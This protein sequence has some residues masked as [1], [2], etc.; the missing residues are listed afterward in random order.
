[1]TVSFNIH[2]VVSNLEGFTFVISCLQTDTHL[3]FQKRIR[4]IL[5]ICNVENMRQPINCY[6]PD[7]VAT[8]TALRS[9]W[10][11]MSQ[12]DLLKF[13]G[14]QPVFLRPKMKLKKNDDVWFLKTAVGKN[15]LGTIIVKLLLEETPGINVGDRV[16]TNKSARRLGVTRM[17]ESL[18]PIE[19]SMRM[20]GHRDLMLYLDA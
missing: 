19:K 17:E 10:P 6:C 13:D 20:T 8:Y 9:H 5:S 3:F 18:V 15:T 14:V 11:S 16:F 7:L 12:K 1:M 2:L 4:W